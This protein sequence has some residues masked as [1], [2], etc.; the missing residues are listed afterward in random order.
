MRKFLRENLYNRV[1][2][3]Q[4][5]KEQRKKYE[6]VCKRLAKADEF[7]KA[8][9]K[10]DSLLK[11]LAIHKDMWGSGFQ[12]K[13]IGPDDCGMFR[14]EDI[15]Q[16][17]PEEVFLGDIYGL[18]T[19]AIPEWENNRN[20]IYGQN[21]FGVNPG[22]RTYELILQQYRHH[23]QSNLHAIIRPEREWLEDWNRQ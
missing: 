11:M 14:T 21:G 17:K 12:N 9:A 19:F 22:T 10:C 16:M 15:L 5:L 2:R 3:K 13:N 6:Q 1:F 23:L 7:D 20:A 8:L 4:Q 18:W